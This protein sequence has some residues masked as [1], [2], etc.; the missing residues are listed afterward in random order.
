MFVSL[1]KE[2]TLLTK[3]GGDATFHL[4]SGL[5]GKKKWKERE[6][7]FD[8]SGAN[9]D[10]VLRNWPDADWTEDCV[11]YRD[12][13]IALK[14][15]E[16]NIRAEK[17][18]ML[19]DSSGYEYKTIPYAHQKQCF[20]LSRDLEYF[21][22]FHEQGCGKSKVAVDTAA[23]L[24]EHGK[25]DRVIV[26]ANNGV[27][28]NWIINE[29]PEHLPERIE[30]TL[31]YFTSGKSK[32]VQ[33]KTR[34]GKLHC[35]AFAIESF[36]SERS[37]EL[38]L[39]WLSSGRCFVVIDE[40]STIKNPSAQR[41]KFICE[42][43]HKVWELEGEG[44]SVTARF[45]K[46]LK[47]Y[48]VGEAILEHLLCGAVYRRIMTG[49]PLTRGIENL[50]SQ[51]FFLNPDILGHRSFWTFRA[52]YCI[53]G[54]FEGKAIVGYKKTE[55]L[56]KLIDG[57]SHRVVKSECLDL[58]PKVYRRVVFDLTKKQRD[59]YTAY[60]QSAVEEILEILEG[61]R[62]E[63]WALLKAQEIAI[64][65]A[66]RLY[67][68][69]CGLMPDDSGQRITGDNPRMDVLKGQLDEA[70]GKTIIWARFKPDLISI[71][72]MLGSKKA[73]RYYGGVSED[74]RIEA[75][76]RFKQD[77]KC[78][79]FVA[80]SAASRGHSLPA[81][82]AIY[83]SQSSSLD[84]RLQSEDR[85]HGIARTI[86]PTTTYTD[87]EAL[88]TVEQRVFKALKANKE[89]ANMIL[90]DPISLFMEEG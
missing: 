61:H 51:F 44:D 30:R 58:P 56:I 46:L 70:T 15:Q 29:I 7:Y 11:A 14:Q 87:L 45:R 59:L 40:S 6:L 67:Q 25:I 21:A 39:D 5:P 9:V 26:I 77:D 68:I 63:D 17:R 84:I 83:H 53:M 16:D 50:Y 81:V 35:M 13:Y 74:E 8:A 33:P 42:A 76:R 57:W 75:T 22:I 27:H 90:Q 48:S 71:Y 18:E 4:L 89:L 80:S 47:M 20:L 19:E 82:G 88:R 55:E 32:N 85:C 79:F 3:M 37:Q 31:A 62:D 12:Q 28:H 2:G 36:V 72:D 86:G 66:L 60:R 69:T 24:Y 10:Y 41:T 64:T 78:Q 34:A 65:K 43:G 52:D 1:L 49:T 23:Y 38:L 54:G 73:V